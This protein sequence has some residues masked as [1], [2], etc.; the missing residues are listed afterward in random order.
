MVVGWEVRRADTWVMFGHH[1]VTV[2]LLAGCYAHAYVP[3]VLLVL[4]LH[5]SCDVLMEAAKLAN[6]C[7]ADRA[8]T[9]LFAVFTAGWAALRLVLFPSVVIR[10]T[11]WEV[12]EVLGGAPPLHGPLNALLLA[13]LAC[14]VYWFVLILRVVLRLL[15]T[16]RA[17]DV[18]EAA[19]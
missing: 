18:R 17:S 12:V 14:H 2:A 10:S 13:L 16:G 7:G 6:Y 9:A 11:L 1:C 8:S 3:A 5:D 4:L 15:A 19:D